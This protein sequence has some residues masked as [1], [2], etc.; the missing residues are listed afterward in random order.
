MSNPI[1]SL[2]GTVKA[3]YEIEKKVDNAELR[4]E[5]ATLKSQLADLKIEHADLKDENRELKD[6]IRLLT[7]NP[8]VFD[9]NV[10]RDTE[11]FAYCPGCFDGKHKACRL[12]EALTL[13]AESKVKCGVCG[14]EYINVL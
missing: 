9:G 7:E 13:M 1:E 12:S 6:R 11:G 4:E 8:L 3:L 10:Y 5:L 14:N 2:A